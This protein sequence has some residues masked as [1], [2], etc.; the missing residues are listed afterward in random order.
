MISENDD[1]HDEN[2]N[3]EEKKKKKYSEDQLFYYDIVRRPELN[4]ENSGIVTTANFQWVS[5][6]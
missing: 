6:I 4:D 1:D 2:Y 5:K 3:P